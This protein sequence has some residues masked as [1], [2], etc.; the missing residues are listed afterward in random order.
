M[1]FSKVRSVARRVLALSHVECEAVG[2]MMILRWHVH[3]AV[4]YGSYC[5]AQGKWVMHS[6]NSVPID[7]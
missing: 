2:H 7:Y 4:L 1:A 3:R 5:V 6:E